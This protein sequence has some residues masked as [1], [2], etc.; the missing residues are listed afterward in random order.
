VP[1][2]GSSPCSL[3]PAGRVPR[4]AARS[5]A[6]SGRVPGRRLAVAAGFGGPAGTRPAD[7]GGCHPPVQYA[8]GAVGE[9]GSG[10]PRKQR[11]TVICPAEPRIGS[12][13]RPTGALRSCSGGGEEKTDHMKAVQITRFGGPD[14]LSVNDVDPPAVGAGEVLVSVEAS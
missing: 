14:V 8:A 11:T 13:D 4:G 1:C 6:V 2:A 10:S 9:G 5:R 3:R 12:T 7:A